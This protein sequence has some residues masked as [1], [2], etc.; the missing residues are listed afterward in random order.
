MKG[1]VVTVT[2][3]G[4][5]LN[6]LPSRV[7][8]RAQ[9]DPKEADALFALIQKNGA[10]SDGQLYAEEK[11]ARVAAAKA[12]RTLQASPAFTASGLR[13]RTRVAKPTGQDGFAFALWVTDAKPEK[14]KS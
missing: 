11:P 10:A 4:F 8:R 7:G 2:F 1:T 12:K 5:D 14:N 9:I 6:T 13:A 3:Q